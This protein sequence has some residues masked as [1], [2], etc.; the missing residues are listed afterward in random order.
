MKTQK[1]YKEGNKELSVVNDICEIL[2]DESNEIKKFYVTDKRTKK[3][4]AKLLNS[5]REAVI[6][7]CNYLGL[8]KRK[9]A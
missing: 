1:N 8:I 6:F 3:I 5:Y 9:E 4:I 2:Y 7:A